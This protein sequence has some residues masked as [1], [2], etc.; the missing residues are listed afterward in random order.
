MSCIGSKWIYNTKYYADGE[1]DMHKSKLVI[2]GNK[3]H[4]IDY[5]EA[6]APV[7]KL[8]IVRSF[9]VVTALDG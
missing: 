9:L 1:L 5:G 7:A 3:Q 2:M 8:A 6:F 4:G